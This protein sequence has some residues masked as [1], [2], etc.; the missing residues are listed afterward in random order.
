[1]VFPPPMRPTSVTIK[2]V[3]AAVAKIKAM[4]NLPCVFFGKPKLK[5]D[6]LIFRSCAPA[7]NNEAGLSC[8]YC[9]IRLNC[10]VCAD[11]VKCLGEY[12]VRFCS[13]DCSDNWQELEMVKRKLR[14]YLWKHPFK[15]LAILGALLTTSCSFIA[16]F[17]YLKLM[18]ALITS[19]ILVMVAAALLHWI[20]VMKAD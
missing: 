6:H 7:V 15:S 1:M 10:E 8:D 4:R 18:P 20:N 14:T 9:G 5:L 16:A 3:A 11:K 19:G 12:S 2:Q 17:Q 13:R